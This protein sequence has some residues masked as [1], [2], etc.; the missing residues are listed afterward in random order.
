MGEVYQARD[1]K[2]GRVVAFKVLKDEVADN[3]DRLSRFHQEARLLA[4]LNHPNIA[5]IFGVV[6]SGQM[7]AIVMEL[8]EGETLQAR[9]TRGALP[10]DESLRIA[11]HVAEA[12]E[13]AHDHR[14]IHRDLKPGNI[15]LT[16]DGKVKVLDFG[17]AKTLPPTSPE[18]NLPK[19]P[20][21][22]A[23]TAANVLMGTPAYMSPEQLR[24]QVSDERSDI[25][26]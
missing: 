22:L 15:N 1:L 11:R 16:A 26:A 7:R 24:G 19:S 4:S 25:W 9:L 12:L 10:C 5:Q 23:P 14:I 21:A 18:T 17:L 2:L 8:V 3:P 13:A 20:T 6:E